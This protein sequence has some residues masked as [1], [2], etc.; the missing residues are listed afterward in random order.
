MDLMSILQS[1]MQEAR[2]VYARQTGN[3]L[4][5]GGGK[6]LVSAALGCAISV[7]ELKA[8]AGEDSGEYPVTMARQVEGCLCR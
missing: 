1:S 8:K 3:H 2:A 6:L 5:I 7:N 4:M